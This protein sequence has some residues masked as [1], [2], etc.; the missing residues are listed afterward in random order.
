MRIVRFEVG[1]APCRRERCGSWKPF[2]RGVR[3]LRPAIVGC[4]AMALLLLAGAAPA[5]AQEGGEPLGSWFMY[6]GQNRVGDRS[7]IHTEAQFRFREVASER[8]QML[9]RVGYDHD[10]GPDDMVTAGVGYVDTRNP[11][12]GPG[13][14]E[15]R[16][17]QQYRKRMRAG[18]VTLEHRLRLEER[19]LSLPRGDE[20]DLRGRY[21]LGATLPL[22]ASPWFLAA[23]EEIFL[24]TNGG[25]FDQNRLYG[26]LGY[27]V[28]SAL[29]L[30]GGFMLWSFRDRSVPTLQLSLSFNPDLR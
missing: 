16:L 8:I 28:D 5:V 21:R 20:F 22:G 15:F 25:A 19:W 14:T 7:S 6:F 18:R 13:A 26:A 24:H 17:W 4:A 11:A 2:E 3:P 10:L 1:G 12:G 27:R 29:S 23:Y 9:F 30:Q